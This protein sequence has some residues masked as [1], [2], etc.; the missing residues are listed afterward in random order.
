MLAVGQPLTMSSGAPDW[1]PPVVLSG[2]IVGI[3]VYTVLQ[4]RREKLESLKELEAELHGEAQGV[5]TRGGLLEQDYQKKLVKSYHLM[6][7]KHASFSFWVS[8]GSAAAGLAM[9][10]WVLSVIVLRPDPGEMLRERLGAQ[11]E[12]KRAEVAELEAADRELDPWRT[13]M[14]R[15]LSE[16][17]SIK[18][19]AG[20]LGITAPEGKIFVA[21]MPEEEARPVN[22]VE[23][24]GKMALTSELILRYEYWDSRLPPERGAQ[25]ES[26]AGSSENEAVREWRLSLST[27][28]SVLSESDP[29]NTDVWLRRSVSDVHS[30]SAQILNAYQQSLERRMTAIEN[31]IPEVR[32]VE[33]PGMERAK[34]LRAGIEALEEKAN[35]SVVANP[36]GF[37]LTDHDKEIVGLV[38]AT[39]LEAIAGLFFVQR[40]RIQKQTTEFF[41]RLRDD[42]RF[43]EAVGL[44]GLLEPGPLRERTVALLA[45]V[46]HKAEPSESVL[47]AMLLGVPPGPPQDDG[48][49]DGS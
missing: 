23:L 17:Q 12:S 8:M 41:D 24:R 49:A 25:P 21:A 5:A 29:S 37:R 38:S 26:S 9:I 35:D 45:M 22:V 34:E 4:Q 36:V 46:L 16:L 32:S 48:R 42:R 44:P 31:T 6:M 40:N 2:C 27:V 14:A 33:S 7:L 1:L 10:L 28:A 47:S 19:E 30:V 11:I 43:N 3:L 13:E 20:K 15:I 39:L 18:D